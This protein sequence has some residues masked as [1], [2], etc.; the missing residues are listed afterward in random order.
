LALLPGALL[1]DW[2]VLDA[3]MS[4]TVVVPGRPSAALRPAGR[5]PLAGSPTPVT[6]RG[7]GEGGSDLLEQRG[8]RHGR[9]VVWRIAGEIL[10]GSRTRPPALTWAFRRLA[11]IR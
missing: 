11:R 1:A 10:W 2:A 8:E 3:L 6:C 4:V 9:R 7:G 5:P